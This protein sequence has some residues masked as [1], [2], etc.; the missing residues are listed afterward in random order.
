[1]YF[2]WAEPE[3]CGICLTGIQG[4]GKYVLELRVVVSELQQRFTVRA[5]LADSEQIFGGGVECRD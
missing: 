2:C 1:M 5:V 4:P 3:F